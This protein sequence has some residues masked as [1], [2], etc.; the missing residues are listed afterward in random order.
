VSKNLK[1]NLIKYGL[2][3]AISLFVTYSYISNKGFHMGTLADKYK[4]ISDG[5]AIPGLL[6]TC[7]G[8]LLIISNEGAFDGISWGLRFAI[9]TLIPFG[10]HKK[11]ESYGDFVEKRRGQ[12]V[13]GFGFVFVVGAI[14]IVICIIFMILFNKVV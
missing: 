2:T 4:Y 5:F 13:K 14:D 3:T 11:Q 9:K 12:K 10:R 7:S 1:A 8:L 6:L